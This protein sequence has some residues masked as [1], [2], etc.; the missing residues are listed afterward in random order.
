MTQSNSSTMLGSVLA[1]LLDPVDR[2]TEGLYTVLIV[3]TF[4]LAYKV[5][6]T[7][8]L[9][10]R[11][12][13]SEDVLQLFWAALGCAVAWGI[14]DGIMYVMTSM[15]ERGQQHRLM[16]AVQQAPDETSGVAVLAT[17]LD[18]E[19]TPLSTAEQRNEIYHALYTKLRGMNPARVGFHREDFAGA[20]GTLMAAVIAALPVTL[21]LLLVRFDPTLAVRLSN[22]IAF[23][24]LYWMG[25][26][27]GKYT[28]TTPW[29]V[30]LLLL[31]V[32]VLMVGIAIPLG[33]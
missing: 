8:T 31:F 22:L 27:W 11:E 4:T 28:G 18:D 20:V 16:L 14:I 15:F 6:Q 5:I 1:R 2:L 24:M 7:N 13:A 29:Q 32:G 19:L 33:G 3:L 10:G 23:A 12:Q 30:G 26:R 17:Q 25:F 21:P 9:A